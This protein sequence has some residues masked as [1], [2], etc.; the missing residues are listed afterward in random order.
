VEAQESTDGESSSVRSIE[1]DARPSFWRRIEAAFPKDS[2]SRLLLQFLLI[3]IVGGLISARYSASLSREERRLSLARQDHA[4]R[5]DFVSEFVK[6][7]N[8]R[9]FLMQ[10]VY[11]ELGR[12]DDVS[13]YRQREL[14]K[15]YTAYYDVLVKWNTSLQYH[16][17][18]LDYHFRFAP[19]NLD[20]ILE[21]YSLERL[22]RGHSVR[23]MTMDVVQ[24]RFK[25]FHEEMKE[26]KDKRLEIGSTLGPDTLEE[27]DRR[28]SQLHEVIYEYM[29]LM[30]ILT[31]EVR[32]HPIRDGEP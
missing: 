31:R 27:L 9:V 25:Y 11:W 7:T 19:K 30:F 24:E 28:Y 2:L 16:V 10:L 12:H 26:A 18:S 29:E 15:K 22:P 13:E 6:L 3:G 1:H 5:Y 21:R 17:S 4:Q 20:E 32:D 14:E 23:S 8:E